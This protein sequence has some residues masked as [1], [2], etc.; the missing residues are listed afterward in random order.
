MGSSHVTAPCAGKLKIQALPLPGSRSPCRDSMLALTA[1]LKVAPKLPVK[2]R[3]S[4]TCSHHR[5]EEEGL[6]QTHR[7]P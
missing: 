4:T 7:I 3:G 5:G 2:S 1:V 6:S